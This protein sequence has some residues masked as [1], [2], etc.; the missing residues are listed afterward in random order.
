MDCHLSVSRFYAN[1][2]HFVTRHDGREDGVHRVLAN[3]DGADCIV[4][5]SSDPF[6]GVSGVSVK[7]VVWFHFS[8]GFG[9][10]PVS[11]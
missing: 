4:G 6:D 11:R 9:S 5:L 7:W 8:V 3:S 2:S 10:I 1:S